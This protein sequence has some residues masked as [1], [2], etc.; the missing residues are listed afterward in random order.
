MKLN[1]L[2][3]LFV[4]LVFILL[5]SG[6]FI[7]TT[8]S[9]SSLSNHKK[10]FLFDTKIKLLMRATNMPSSVICI[11]KSNSVE[12]M[13]PYGYKN[14]YLRQKATND[15][16]YSLGSV[17]K[18]V[19]AVALMQLY[20][21]GHFDLDDDISKFLSFNVKNPRYPNTNITFRMILAH[22]A[23]LNDFGVK[24]IGIPYM[25]IQAWLKNN[26]DS[27]IEEMLS[28][29]GRIYS[30]RYFTRYEPGE[31][32][33]Y[34]ELAFILVGH[35]IE[36]I[37]GQSLEEYCQEN[38][39]E[40]LGMHNTSFYARKLNRSK[41]SQPH[42]SAFQGLIPLPKYDLK[43]L[44][45][46]AG[47][48]TNANDLSKFFIALINNGSY[49]NIRILE[50]DTVDLMHTKQ[51]P[52]SKDFLLG[53]MFRAKTTVHHGLGWFFIN[54]FDLEL[55]GH[56]GGAP[57]YSCHMYITKDK[58][59]ETVGIIVLANG[60]ML[61]PALVSSRIVIKGYENILK[62]IIEKAGEI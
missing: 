15:T 20:D 56:T 14:F 34:G 53:L 38:I 54:V 47:L 37:S 59:N 58:K 50:K 60:P 55:E 16:I 5:I 1:Y 19:S 39:F 52:N 61:F 8:E 48:W 41:I 12:F 35:L 23:G 25:L 24:L 40:P 28:E 44:D 43:M 6:P 21:E 51:Y 45:A 22:Q 36:T 46:P 7:I 49:K 11:I 13:Q 27:L 57:G 10:H 18:A 31:K 3:R 26:S 9:S 30:K 32:A 62:L 33:L 2:K 42:I 29:D 4:F 17:S